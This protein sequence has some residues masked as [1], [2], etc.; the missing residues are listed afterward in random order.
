[1]SKP[2]ETQDEL[3]AKAIQHFINTLIDAFETG[4]VEQNTL[5]LSELY[6]IAQNHVNDNY[7]VEIPSLTEQWGNECAKQCGFFDPS[8]KSN[9]V[10]KCVRIT[11][12]HEKTSLIQPITERLDLFELFGNGDGDKYIIEVVDIDESEYEKMPDFDGF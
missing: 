5:T 8:E 3:K 1:M 12:T 11:H 4:H 7:G 2:V 6:R 9:G 10:I